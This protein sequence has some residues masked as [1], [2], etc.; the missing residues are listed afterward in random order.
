MSHK[1][2]NKYIFGV[3]FQNINKGASLEKLKDIEIKRAGEHT[4]ACSRKDKWDMV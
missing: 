4:N 2:I 1:V 3:C